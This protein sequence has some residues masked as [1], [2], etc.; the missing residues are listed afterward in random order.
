VEP[1]GDTF[2]AAIIPA[3]INATTFKG[4]RVGDT[5]NL[6]ADMIG[7]YL[8]H[9]I[10]VSKQGNGVTLDFLSKHGFV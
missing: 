2:G 7:K 10:N 1:S 3:T 5:V 9:Y 4:K 8:H 6:E